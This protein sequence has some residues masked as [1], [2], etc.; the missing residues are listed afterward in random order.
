[1][2][3]SEVEVKR[4]REGDWHVIAISTP[5]E[6]V[7]VRVTPHGRIRVRRVKSATRKGLAAQGARELSKRQRGAK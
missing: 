2:A 3:A 5:S 7:E 1:V 6:R 4:G